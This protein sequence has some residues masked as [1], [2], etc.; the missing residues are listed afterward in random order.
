MK[1]EKMPDPF[2]TLEKIIVMG[3]FLGKCA[4]TFRNNKDQALEFLADC[5][6]QCQHTNI[7]ELWG[8]ELVT[9]ILQFVDPLR[10]N[11]AIYAELDRSLRMDRQ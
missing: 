4:E 7:K 1:Q 3:T 5:A 6:E 9:E 10:D 8:E 11:S 2:P